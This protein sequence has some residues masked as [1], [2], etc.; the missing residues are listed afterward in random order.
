MPGPA[1]WR[2]RGR[3]KG[4]GAGRT[5]A[6]GRARRDG[7]VGRAVRGRVAGEAGAAV[8]AP[9]GPGRHLADR[10]PPATSTAARPAAGPPRQW[11]PGR[12]RRRQPTLPVPPAGPDRPA[13][14][15]TPPASRSPPAVVSASVT[16]ASRSRRAAP[17]SEAPAGGGWE[18]CAH[19]LGHRLATAARARPL[20]SLAGGLPRPGRF[21]RDQRRCRRVLAEV[22]GTDPGV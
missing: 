18:A 3:G 7:P 10:W 1:C 5:A 2:P 14:P 13:R 16:S 22:L 11:P 9:P 19:G 21:R 12:P 17:P 8:P 6:Q 20:R 15:Q 4:P